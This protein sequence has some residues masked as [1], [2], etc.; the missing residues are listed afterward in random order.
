MGTKNE[1]HVT[2]GGKTK[3]GKSRITHLIISALEEAG[4]AVEIS[5]E[6]LIDYNGDEEKF[7][8]TM[9]RDLDKAILAID[10]KS[11]IVIKN[12]QYHRDKFKKG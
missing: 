3:V 10:K 11:K 9:E 1:I 6:V 2:I 12:V 8:A 7:T 4:L 5:P